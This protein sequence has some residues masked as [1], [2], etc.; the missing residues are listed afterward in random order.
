MVRRYLSFVVGLAFFAALFAMPAQAGQSLVFGVHPFKSTSEL[1]KMF[2]PL[3]DYLEKET[4]SSIS[5][6]TAKNY[7][8][9]LNALLAGDMH[10][11][12][13]GPS[14]FAIASGQ[15]ADKIHLLGTASKDGNPT[16]KGV[17]IAKEGSS[18]N[19]LADL[20]GKK[21]AFGDRE[22]TLSCYVPAHMLMQAGIFESLEYKFLGSHDNV[23]KAVQLGMFDAGGI[24][25]AVAAKYTGQGLKII[26]ESEPVYEHVLVASSSVDDETLKKLRLA[27]LNLKDPAVLGAIKKG[28]SGFM[29]VDADKYN[30][31][32]QLMNDVDAKIPH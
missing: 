25:P 23:A 5:F 17:I 30:S 19:S 2:R 6:R 7:D 15:H 21:F 10:I 32:R 1:A 4:G 22:S 27:V 8:A 24:K 13:M 16:F 18:I 26:A 12:F 9:A 11:S 3:I 28:L 20:K 14:L 31:L 29:E